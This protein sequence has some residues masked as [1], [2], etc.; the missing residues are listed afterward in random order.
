M[1]G[2]MDGWMDRWIDRWMDGWMDLWMD[3]VTSYYICCS[4]WH[5]GAGWIELFV[6]SVRVCVCFSVCVHMCQTFLCKVC[7]LCD[8]MR[9]ESQGECD[10]WCESNSSLEVNTH[11]HT[12]THAHWKSDTW[13]WLSISAESRVLISLHTNLPNYWGGHKSW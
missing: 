2:Q 10:V 8:P 4:V 1:G 11:T 13:L 7:F 9:N 12:H 6:L 5:M 3:G